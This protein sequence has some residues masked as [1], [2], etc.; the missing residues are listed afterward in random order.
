M[1]SLFIVFMGNGKKILKLMITNQQNIRLPSNNLECY[2]LGRLVIPSYSLIR[3]YNF[4][5]IKF[6]AT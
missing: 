3:Q 1:I 2:Q 4:T 6:I 5:N